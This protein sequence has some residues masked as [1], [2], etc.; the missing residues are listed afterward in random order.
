MIKIFNL[1]FISLFATIVSIESSSAGT[2]C[3]DDSEV[4]QERTSEP[5]CHKSHTDHNKE[6]K[7]TKDCDD[8]SCKMPCCHLSLTPVSL[9]LKVIAS[10]NS[11]S[12]HIISIIENPKNY[13]FQIFRPPIA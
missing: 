5:D 12:L 11:Y 10:L 13:P 8:N 4:K 2:I 6:S 3:H 7:K 1:I 9:P